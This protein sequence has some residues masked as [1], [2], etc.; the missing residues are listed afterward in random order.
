MARVPWPRA[1]AGRA[2]LCAGRG[3][4]AVLFQA[5]LAGLEIAPAVVPGATGALPVFS[6][7]GQI[8]LAVTRS[9]LS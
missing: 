2:E 7:P 1:T 6:P 5:K 9:L 3:V 8:G 4:T